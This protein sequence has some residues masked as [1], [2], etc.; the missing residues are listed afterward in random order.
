MRRPTGF[1]RMGVLWKMKKSRISGLILLACAVAAGV[2]IYKG[3]VSSGGPG[4]GAAATDYSLTNADIRATISAAGWIGPQNRLEITPPINGRVVEILVKE[5]ERVKA[6]QIVAWMSSNDRA[7]LLDAAK[8]KGPD[9]LKYWSEVYKPTPLIAPIDGEVI[10][11]DVE[12]GQTINTATAVVVLSDRLIVKARVDETD[13]GKVKVGQSAEVKL[14]AY[15]E[16]KTHGKV[17]HISYESRVM[18]NITIYFVEIAVDETPSIF[19][20]GMNAEIKIIFEDRRGVP[21]L[22]TDVV[23]RDGRGPFVMV[24]NPET[25]EAEKRLLT[26]GGSDDRFTEIVSGLEPSDVVIRRKKSYKLAEQ[27]DSK[28]P[29]LP[30]SAKGKGK[31]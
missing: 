6:G 25:G 4:A 17:D 9:E 15:P 8:A 14:D 30:S 22:P 1:T 24:K 31:K 12:P 7:A 23:Q 2:W 21:A 29:F 3:G 13:I 10:V 26:L 16:V 18:N 19:R 11:R 5:G 27:K 20:S 28:N